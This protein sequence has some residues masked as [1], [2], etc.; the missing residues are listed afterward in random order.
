MRG[1]DSRTEGG[2]RGVG[3]GESN[4]VRLETTRARLY[5]RRS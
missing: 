4:R 1:T 3:N 2:T 5:I